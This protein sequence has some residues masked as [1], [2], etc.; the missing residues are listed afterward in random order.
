MLVRH[1]VSAVCG[2]A[3]GQAEDECLRNYPHDRYFIGSLYPI[4]AETVPGGGIESGENG[5]PAADDGETETV[6]A[7]SHFAELRSKVAPVAFGGEFQFYPQQDRVTV[8]VDIRWASYYRVFPT[9]QQQR[10]YQMWVQQASSDAGTGD[11]QTPPSEAAG[12]SEDGGSG[13]HIAGAVPEPRQGARSR[14]R[15]PTEDLCPRFRKIN[16]SATGGVVLVRRPDGQWHIDP[17]SL[18]VALA[19]EC[20]RAQTIVHDDQTSLRT[21]DAAED[22]VVIAPDCLSTEESYRSFVRSLRT[23]VQPAWQWQITP[24]CRRGESSDTW[25]F[26]IQFANA[27]SIAPDASNLEGFFFDTE[28][29]F[30]LD[31]GDIVPLELT[32]V[33]HGFRYNREMWGRGFNCAIERVPD[34]PRSLRTNHVPVFDQMRL[35]ARTDPPAKF[36]DLAADPVHPL[37]VIL[38]E[39]TA[40]R[41][42]W[43]KARAGYASTIPQWKDRFASEF[44][45]DA[46]AFEDEVRRFERGLQLIEIDPDIRLAFQLTNEAFRRTG[47]EGWRLFQVVFI[48][49]QIVSIAALNSRYECFAKERRKVDI[50]YFPTGGGKTEAYLGVIIF[51]CFYDRLRGKPAGVTAWTRFP[52]RLLTLQQTQ[53]AAD[54]IG[55]AELVRR[56]QQDA[57]LVGG[58]VDGFAVG[59]FV[60]EGGSPNAILP[61]SDQGG[62]ASAV[63]SQANDPK[64][65]QQWKRVLRCPACRTDSVEVTF[66][67]GASRLSHR[68]LNPNCPFPSGVLPVYIVDNEIYRYLPSLIVGTIDKLASMGLQRKF[69]MLFGAVDGKCPVHGYFNGLCCQKGCSER[70]RWHRAP[71]GVSGVTLLVQDELHLLKEGMGT[72]DSHYETFAQR[73]RREFGH[74]DELKT[75][76]SSATI[77]AFER[78]VVHLYGRKAEDARCFPGRGPHLG[79]SFYTRTLGYPQRVFVGVIP[80]NK[81][82][83]NSV[84][85]LIEYYHREMCAI[86]AAPPVDGNP[87]GGEMTPA[88]RDYARIVDLYGTSLTYF[89]SKRDLNEVHTDIEGDVNGNLAYEGLPELNVSELTGGTTTDDVSR[90]LSRLERPLSPGAQPDAVLATSM[91]SH[92]VDVD[93]LNLMTFHGMPRLT[94]EYVQ[95]SSRVGRSSVGMVFV[96]FHPMRERDR[97]H[98]AYFSKYHEYLGQ[99]VEP[100]A[101]NRWSRFSVDRTIPG[102]FMAV[103]LQVIANKDRQGNPDRYYF[104][105]YVEKQITGNRIRDDHFI[106]FLLEAYQVGD[107]T[108][109]GRLAFREAITRLV[110]RF[111]YD[112]IVGAGTQEQSISHVLHP[113]PLLSLRDVDD[114]IVIELDSAGTQWAR[115]FRRG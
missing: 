32:L 1:L 50:I 110:P 36:A 80:H 73:V 100:V 72:F 77:E 102:L 96:C 53:R 6:S 35:E 27:S 59:Y 106:S 105:D 86:A 11:A 60:G 101:V 98:Y 31:G 16:C 20:S 112:Q 26:A 71:K 78:Q 111:L 22:K 92:G 19:N 49:S 82:I 55:L 94:G 43:E 4:E 56:E 58:S 84:L 81:T 103:L 41:A 97:S 33:P 57:R 25:L 13:P 108:D 5:P 109:P 2:R 40:Y 12:E 76:A 51:H 89:N 64:E 83:L 47:K 38:R 69:A 67:P 29:I 46:S 66:D 79:S 37:R 8:R 87:Y 70:P 3:S 42:Q 21:A 91:V 95:A 85:E 115:R 45:V 48:V 24:E 65:C 28:A 30:S 14:R 114:P 99:M 90:I 93:R 74:T 15:L 23:P 62:Q 104:R 44:D 54:I 88:S 107:A 52:L 18:S 17:S 39:M 63:W 113:R 75:I 68:C 10:D 34:Q 61:P 7:R 9:L